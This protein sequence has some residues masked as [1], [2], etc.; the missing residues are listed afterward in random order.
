MAKELLLARDCS[1]KKARKQ[2][3]DG[4]AEQRDCKSLITRKRGGRLGNNSLALD[5]W[6]LLHDL[7]NIMRWEVEIV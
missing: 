7:I 1:H 5:K 4:N 2:V 6:T 3:N